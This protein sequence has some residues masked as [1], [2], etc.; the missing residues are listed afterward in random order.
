MAQI[1]NNCLTFA[2]IFLYLFNK[3][4]INMAKKIY[5][6]ESQLK[7]LMRKSIMGE[8]FISGKIAEET[9]NSNEEEKNK[10]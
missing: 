10:N 9:V 8:D 4:V 5:V 1:Y 3:N 7:N 2:N 6:T